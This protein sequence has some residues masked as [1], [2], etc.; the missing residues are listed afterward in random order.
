M[1]INFIKVIYRSF[2]RSKFFT[3]INVAGLAIGLAC[4]IAIYLYI[5]HELSFDNFHAHEQQIYRVLRKS[6]IHGIPYTIGVTSGPYA[7]ALKNDY[8]DRIVD[9]TRALPFDGLVSYGEKAFSEERLMLADSNFFSFF[10]YRLRTGDPA[11]VLAQPNDVVITSDFAKKYF[12]DEDPIGK[13]IRLDNEDDL[14]VTGILADEQGESHLK[15]DMVA[16]LALVQNADWFKE[17]WNNSMNTYVR[18]DDPAHAKYLNEH[19]PEF[20][21]KYFGEDFARVGNKIGLELEPLREI[22]FNKD[23]RYE[24]GVVHGDRKYLYIFG[25]VGILLIL[26]AAINYM[27]LATAQSS[28]RAREVGVRKTLGSGKSKV[29]AQFMI[30]SG[31]M[32]LMAGVLALIILQAGMPVLN[33]ATGIELSSVWKSPHVWLFIGGT[34]IVISLL[35]GSYPA[36]LLSSFQPMNVLKGEIKGSLRYLFVRKVLVVF[37][38]SISIFMIIATLLIGRQ[39]KFMQEKDLGFNDDRVMIVRLNNQLMRDKSESFRNQVLADGTA[40]Y[41]AFASGHPGGFHDAS[42]IRV[43]GVEES[44]R[45]R[46]LF[47]TEGFDKVLDLEYVAGR[48]FSRDFPGDSLHAVIINETSAKAL[49]LTATEAI[50]RKVMRA[51][52]DTIYR[53]IIGV[54]KDYNFT[55]LHQN[56]EPLII[57]YGRPRELVF[58]LG[59][60]NLNDAIAGIEKRWDSYGSGFPMEWTF[61]SDEMKDLYQRELVQGKIF[62]IFSIVAVFIAC[63]GILG[64]TSFLAIQRKK[65]IGIR[66]ILGASVEQVSMLLMKDLLILVLIGNIIA[67]PLTYSVTQEWLNTFAYRIGS[68]PQLFLLGGFSVLLMVVVIAGVRAVITALENPVKAIRPE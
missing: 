26:L 53:E 50:G 37:Q 57:S 33:S 3:V 19:F 9:V 68:E 34:V 16:S 51:Q 67:I 41:A 44:L 18:I 35:A 6:E 15:F 56:I 47:A 30:E 43:E 60:G 42:S 58:K 45:M 22:Y 10:S 8:G 55:S 25:S 64:L 17:W 5:R 1:L 48:S 40:Q 4:T 52:S 38:F 2:L 39:M 29:A 59:G 14:K 11:T 7:G 21:N 46:T 62:T 31:V 36:I 28:K 32:C 49:G 12:G 54:V 20:M 66:K 61:L 23:T 63:L 65:E 13:T 24:S 27:N